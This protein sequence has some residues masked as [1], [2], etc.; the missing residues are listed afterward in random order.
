M[1]GIIPI[2]KERGMTSHDV[3]AKVRG[4][5]RTKKVGHSG[6]L[7]PSVDGVLPVCVGRATKV[8]DYLMRFG[9]T[10]QGSITL[11]LATTTEDLDGEVVERQPLSKPLTDAQIEAALKQMTGELTQIPPM[12][13][14]VKVNGRKLYEYARAGETVERPK[15]KIQVYQFKQIRPTEFDEEKGEQ[16]IYF[17]VQCGKGTYVRTLAVDFGRQFGLPAVMSDLTRTSSGGFELKECVTLAE[18]EQARD[19]DRVESDVLH[20]IDHALAKF[21]AIEIT[22]S[23]WQLVQNG[24][25][26]KR[27]LTEP[28]VAVKYKGKIQALYQYDES[29]QVYRPEKMLLVR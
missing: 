7:D 29:R 26:L 23:E 13:S 4:I 9:K 20:P 28:V 18:L 25:F 12:Y 22:D 3:V 5:L 21:E 2:N 24:G 1:D 17:E 11:G 27:A 14:A 15:R 6:T 16:T 10:Y 8:V 19:E